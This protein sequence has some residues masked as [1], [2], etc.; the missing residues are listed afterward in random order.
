MTIDPFLTVTFALVLL[1][2]GKELIAR[3][4][5]LRRY[6]IPE[7]LVGGVL[8]ACSVCLLYYTAGI[9]IAFDL[10]LRDPLLLYFFA[11]IGLSTDLRTLADGGKPLLILALLAIG[12]ILLQNL[13][14]MGVAAAFGLDPRAGLMV[15]SVTGGVGTT[16]A[17]APHFR[18]SLGIA[19]AAELG[20]AANMIGLIAACSIGGPIANVLMRWHQVQPSDD[21][22]LEVGTL[23]R[24]E[25]YL[26]LD[27]HGMLLALLWLNLTLILGQGIT[28]LF[29]AG[30]LTLPA[31][32]GCLLG[33]ILLRNGAELLS[34]GQGR[35][36]NL[37]SMQPGLALSSEVCL[38]LFLTMALMGL[39]LWEL[40]PVLGFISI[41]LLLQIALAVLFI[42]LV[43]F[44][45]LG[46]DYEAAVVCSGFGGIALGSTATAVANM[47][48]VT[49]EFGA[50]RK[51]F[52]IVPL[53]CG[54]VIDLAN[55]VIIGV[56]A[57]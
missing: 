30:G 46:R 20:L 43:V 15:G 52:V 26:R 4:E 39:R 37:A 1:F 45:A 29:T 54:F 31:F 22:Q 21:T 6:S 18:D 14:G 7:A 8:C 27:Y 33:G 5:L 57:R 24:Y 35:L 13:A 41:A 42:L 38:G 47:S 36:W 32:V 51:A 3:C 12:F 34:G 44:R 17:W 23:H 9:S 53:V 19:G 48:A 55:A 28:S 56:L 25:R 11:S 49:R 10:E 40:Q 50:A 2:V 16:L